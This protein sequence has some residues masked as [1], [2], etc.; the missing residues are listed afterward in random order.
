M[1]IV[2]ERSSPNPQLSI[3]RSMGPK[4]S[5]RPSPETLTISTIHGIDFPPFNPLL[6]VLLFF[7]RH[8]NSAGCF[9]GHGSFL[10]LVA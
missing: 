3:D 2:L 10:A 8:Y 6:L 1:I 7:S 4:R 9:D 5:I